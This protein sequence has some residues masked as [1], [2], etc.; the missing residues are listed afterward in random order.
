MWVQTFTATVL[1]VA[2]IQKPYLEGGLVKK[3]WHLD[4]MELTDWMLQKKENEIY[5]RMSFMQI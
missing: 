3:E 1:V 2:G 4:T 5:D